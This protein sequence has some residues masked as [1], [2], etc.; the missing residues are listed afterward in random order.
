MRRIRLLPAV[1]TLALLAA[2]ASADPAS[3]AVTFT[4]PKPLAPPSTWNPGKALAAT[5]HRLLA[6]WA[7]DCPPPRGRCATD[8]GP[9]MGVFVQRALAADRTP[10]WSRPHRV[11]PTKVQ[12]ERATLAADG[13]VAVVGWVTQTSYL[14][15]DASAPRVFQ[16]RVSVDEGAHWR[17]TRTLSP[18]KGRVDYP[19]VAVGGGRMYA[20]WTDAGTGAI[21]L[22]ISTDRGTTWKKRTIGTTTSRSTGFANGYAG[23]PDI[24]VRGD[25]LAVVWFSGPGGRQVAL[26]SSTGGADLGPTSV[27]V[28]LTPSSPNDGVRYPGA[29]RSVTPNDPRVALAY[30]TADSLAVRI[31]DGVI[32]GD[33]I[34]VETW[35]A[36]VSGVVYD[37]GYGP[38]VLAVRGDGIVVTFAGCRRN[39]A[40][41]D[42]CDPLAS[43]AR[44]D[45]LYT[46]S[47]NGGATWSPLRRLTD[48]SRAPYKVS[49][50]PSLAWTGGIRRV[51]YDRYQSSFTDYRVWFRSAS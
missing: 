37:S 44:I 34:T 15:E 20:V 2:L 23:L 31:F 17:P 33:P 5:T 26:T 1:L 30:T 51:A 24:A 7:S 28:A 18:P 40:L 10:P 39:A 41:T 38:A 48:A 19:R 3:A 22:A 9:Y 36:T 43:G 21:R 6:A 16:A 13:T 35:P 42:P 49:D 32:L 12:S 4:K 50:E 27:P 46:E 11:S 45:L 8:A 25:D 29:G 14:H 47:T